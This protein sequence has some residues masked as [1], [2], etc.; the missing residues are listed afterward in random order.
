MIELL[1]QVIADSM[2]RPLPAVTPRQAR[3]PWL[4]G[5]VDTVTGM[6]RSGKT[7]FLYQRMAELLRAGEPRESVLYLNFEDERFLPMGASDLHLIPE[8]FY[9][10]YPAMKRRECAFL[11]D[12][13]QN[14]EGW[15]RFS[16]R[17][18]DTEK[19]H[20]CLTGSSARLLGREIA[21]SLRGRAIETEIFPFS[22][23]E[24]LVHAGVR[25][26]EGPPGS[27]ATAELANRCDAYLL[28]GG[29]PEVQGLDPDLRV[30]VLQEYVD[31]VLL[32]DVIE[33]H[34][35]TN[36]VALRHLVRHL[37]AAPGAAFSVHKFYNDLRSRGVA[38]AKDTLHAALDHLGDAFLV[39]PVPIRSRSE[40]ARMVNPRKVYS[41]DPG[42]ARALSREPRGDEARLLETVVFLDLRRRGLEVE[43][44]VTEGGHEV[45]F[46]A[47]PRSGSPLLVQ[48]CRSL[49][50]P[51]TRA[52]ETSALEEAMG[53]LGLRH[54]TVVTLH[55]SET[56]RVGRGSIAVVPAW[57]FLLRDRYP[58]A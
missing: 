16:R 57:R 15:E 36:T 9:R 37:L 28:T 20:L 47:T 46:V 31:V 51:L 48:V 4:R 55:E 11:F 23:E 7:F 27:Q 44:L 56:L 6:R 52:R 14:V 49:R 3:L 26:P 22:F 35:L 38:V 25:L 39:F 1:G 45:D 40:R 53:A 24:A 5:K 8:T 32:R 43:Y 18:V 10:L 54:G 12:E 33:R 29:F 30:R 41:I 58:I 13:I 19:V 21:T 50:D 2:E 42:L 34:E 17:L